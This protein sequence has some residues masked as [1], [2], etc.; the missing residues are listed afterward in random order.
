MTVQEIIDYARNGELR[1]LSIAEISS[2]PLVQAQRDAAIIT[3]INLGLIELYK[4][5]SLS[6]KAEIVRTTPAVNM[7]YLRNLDIF[8]I[9][10]IYDASGKPLIEPQTLEDEEY[11]VKPITP[12]VYL[13]REPIDEEVAFVYIASPERVTKVTD[14][15][16]L[17]DIMLESLLHYIGYRAH[18][19]MNGNVDGENNT[20]YLRFEKSCDELKLLGFGQVVSMPLR[21]LNSKGF[22]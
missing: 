5:F 3:Y 16:V 8:R 20:H 10:N 17:L 9:I 7:Y 11:D 18:G 21:A 6:V 15:V 14:E 13:F 2:D 12:T 19:A 4:R 1:Q 22:V